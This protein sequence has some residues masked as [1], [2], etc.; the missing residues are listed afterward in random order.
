MTAVGYVLSA[1]LLSAGAWFY[2]PGAG[3]L[4]AGV[5]VAVLTTLL[6]L[7]VGGDG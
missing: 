6:L 3:M 2:S 4:T 5:C 1:C 7:D